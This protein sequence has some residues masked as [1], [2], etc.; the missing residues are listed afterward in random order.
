MV[1][2]KRRQAQ[3]FSTCVE[4]ILIAGSRLIVPRSILHVCGGDPKIGFKW[5]KGKEYSPR[6][7]R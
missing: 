5:V 2:L 1:A 3:V 6:V 7:W 4:V